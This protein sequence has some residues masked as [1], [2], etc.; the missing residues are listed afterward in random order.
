MK[1]IVAVLILLASLMTG[2]MKEIDWY[3]VVLQFQIQDS[4]GND[5]LDPESSLFVGE[6]ITL[7]FE[8]NDYVI[9]PQ[10]KAY[11]PLFEGLTLGKSSVTGMWVAR[12]GE[13]GGGT[14]RHDD[15]VLTFSDGS[16][17]TIHYDR[18]INSVTVSARQRWYLDGKKVDLPIPVV[19]NLARPKPLE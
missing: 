11:A 13:L 16:S 7:S 18:T 1:R 9:T 4:A 6:K 19:Y 14:N 15:F 3:P 10:T 8:G 5:L 12:F 2:C 17:K